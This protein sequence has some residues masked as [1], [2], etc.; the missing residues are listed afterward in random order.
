RPQEGVLRPPSLGRA[1]LLNFMDG[2]VT[3][4][5]ALIVSILLARTLGPER[6]GL[7]ALV[8]SVVVVA[9]LLARLG[10][11]STVKRFVAELH[12]REEVEDI[13]AVVGRSLRLGLASGAAGS[14]VLAAGAIPLAAFFRHA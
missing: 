2:G 6:F 4:A 11:S 1:T 7:Y 8:M 13:K 3:L 9:L 5:A 12:A 14:V 10:I